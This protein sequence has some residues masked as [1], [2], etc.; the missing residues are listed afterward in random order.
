MRQ[1]HMSR[2]RPLAALAAILAAAA[3]DGGA[4]RQQLDRSAS[5]VSK[6]EAA[7][8]PTAIAPPSEGFASRA[9][10]APTLTSQAANP[11]SGPAQFRDTAAVVPS[12]IIRTGQATVEVD[13]L[14]IAVARVRELAQRVG[15][16]IANTSVQTGEHEVR[17]A[18]LEV[19]LPADRWAQAVGGLSPIGKVESVNEA[20]E[21]VGEE[22][23]DVTARVANTRRLEERLVTL[24]ATRTGK[25][26]DVL[27]VERELA[28]VREEIERYEGRIRYL[29][30]RVSVSTLTVTVHEPAPLIGERP[31]SNVMGEAF[32]DAWRNFVAFVASFIRSLGVLIPLGVLA[33]LA[34]RLA[35][36]LGVGRWR[37]KPGAW[38]GGSPGATSG[39]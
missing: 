32:R 27:A 15:G 36:R 10:R 2:Y 39:A 13:S 14:E 22:F 4:Q 25:L 12:M 8:A 34:W 30:T 1:T 37:P 29:R 28:R 20:T 6:D 35:R 7:P 19:K 31:G 33:Y 11:P 5:A 16:Y 9:V 24:L 3:C 18:T 17:S 26:E 23:V 38:P 21:D